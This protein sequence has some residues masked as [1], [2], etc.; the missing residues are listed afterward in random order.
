ME[1]LGF[2]HD[3]HFT[4]LA[5]LHV[6]DEASA[7]SKDH[8]TQGAMHLSLVGLSQLLVITRNLSQRDDC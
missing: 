3:Q 7:I 4:A 8:I 5:R 2:A 1:D 6:L